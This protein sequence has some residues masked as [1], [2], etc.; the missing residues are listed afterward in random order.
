MDPFD[1]NSR[2]IRSVEE[3]ETFKD[4][5]DRSIET[6]KSAISSQLDDPIDIDEWRQRKKEAFAKAFH[7]EEE[8]MRKAIERFE[9]TLGETTISSSLPLKEQE[10]LRTKLTAMIHQSHEEKVH[11]LLEGKAK[12]LTKYFW[13]EVDF[14]KKLSLDAEKIDAE[15]LNG[16]KETFSA[17]QLEEIIYLY[18]EVMEMLQDEADPLSQTKTIEDTLSKGHLYELREELLLAFTEMKLHI[19]NT[20]PLVY[21]ELTKIRE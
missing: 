11:A 8:A 21:Q 2:T 20:L 4:D 7:E 10:A 12:L 9:K 14:L 6:S 5:L 16:I 17:H 19:K 3:L 15:T 18:R 1:P 13:R